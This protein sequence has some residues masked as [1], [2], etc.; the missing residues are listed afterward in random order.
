M[1]EVLTYMSVILLVEI[2]YLS[3]QKADIEVDTQEDQHSHL[4]S[5]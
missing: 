4:N 1:V 5:A 3:K 2:A